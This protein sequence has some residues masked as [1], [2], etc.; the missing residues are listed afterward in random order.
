N[1]LVGLLVNQ[2]RRKPFFLLGMVLAVLST[3]GYVF[4]NGL[5]AMVISRLLW[6]AGWALV[7]LTSMAIV[8]DVTGESNRGRWMGTFNTFYLVGIAL[9]SLLG[10][11]LSDLIGFRLAMAVCAGLTLLGGVQALIFL[12]ETLQMQKVDRP[13]KKTSRSLGERFRSYLQTIF[14]TK[15]LP[16]LLLIYMGKQFAAEGIALSLLAILLQERFGEGVTLMGT[17]IGIAT[18]NGF[19]LAF[20]YLLSAVLSP[21]V[22]SLSDRGSNGRFWLLT[23]SLAVS[24]I[25]FGMIAWCRSLPWIVFAMVLNAIDGAGSH[26]ALAALVADRA[27]KDSAGKVLGIYATAGDLGSALGPMYGY[28]MLNFVSVANVF[29]ISGAIL[30]VLCLLPGIFWLREP[31]LIPDPSA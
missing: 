30:L 29:L 15:G 9:G 27:P 1:P 25:S 24:V 20:R 13:K 19:M 12:P 7:F 17:L 5:L 14:S 3:L 18:L 21:M 10:G 23:F 26:V 11:S 6:G 4:A 22:G 16:V 28:F 8:M 31:V 2:R